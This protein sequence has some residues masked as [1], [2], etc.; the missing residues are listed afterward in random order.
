MSLKAF[1][2]AF[3]SVSTLL[4]FGCSVWGVLQYAE[5]RSAEYILFA[6]TGLLGGIGLIFYGRHFLRKLKG[7]SYL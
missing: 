5:S 7:I 1:H 3:I 6:V 2:I 4:C